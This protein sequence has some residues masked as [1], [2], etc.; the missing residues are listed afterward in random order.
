MGLPIYSGTCR[1]GGNWI[2]FRMSSASP[3]TQN[4]NI[5]LQQVDNPTT[6]YDPIGVNQA[7]RNVWVA[8]KPWIM[9]ASGQYQSGSISGIIECL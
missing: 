2:R 1:N 4:Y 8:Q 5:R 6:S 7:T 9:M 3:A